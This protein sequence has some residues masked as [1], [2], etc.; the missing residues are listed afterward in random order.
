MTTRRPEPTQH[1]SELQRNVQNRITREKAQ[2]L[3]DWTAAGG[4]VADF[5]AAW[6][7]IHAQLGQIRVMQ[8]GHKARNRSLRTFRK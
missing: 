3:H 1:T 7:S 8:I 4:T 2:L 6:P 5:E